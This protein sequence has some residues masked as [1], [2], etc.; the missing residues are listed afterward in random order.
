M[1]DDAIST[2]KK[3][4]NVKPV[5]GSV[6]NLNPGPPT[7]AAGQFLPTITVNQRLVDLL[8]AKRLTS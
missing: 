1:D 4:G 3:K 5:F 7:N 8:Y 2:K 6:M